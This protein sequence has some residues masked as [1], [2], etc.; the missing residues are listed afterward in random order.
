MN[1]FGSFFSRNSRHSLRVSVVVE[2]GNGRFLVVME[3][4]CSVGLI[5]SASDDELGCVCV[6]VLCGLESAE[7][8]YD[9]QS[10]QLSV[11]HAA[12][13]YG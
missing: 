3:C 10:V 7:L 9:E 12:L 5:A 6:S 8:C 13:E 11:A 4:V 2:F 1:V